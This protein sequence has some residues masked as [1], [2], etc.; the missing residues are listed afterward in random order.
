MLAYKIIM[1][2]VYPLTFN[3][4]PTDLIYTKSIK[5]GMKLVTIHTLYIS[6]SYSQKL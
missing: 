3:F 4:K 6:I 2:S 5:K 1:L